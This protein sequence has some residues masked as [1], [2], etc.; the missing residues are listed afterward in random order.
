[1]KRPG[2]AR[3]CRGRSDGSRPARCVASRSTRGDSSPRSCTRNAAA[4]AERTRLGSDSP[5]RRMKW[6]SWANRSATSCMASI[7][8]RV[9]PTP[10]GPVKVTSRASSSSR[11]EVTDTQLGFP[12]QE[13]ASRKWQRNGH[14][15]FRIMGSQ[16]ARLAALGRD[17]VL[18]RSA[19]S[20]DA[21]IDAVSRRGCSMMPRSRSL[22]D[23]ALTP[24]RSASSCCVSPASTRSWRSR[25][26][27]PFRS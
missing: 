6:T 26:A 16:P 12:A 1:M 27:N 18:R 5:S 21:S 9:F 19:L 20:P 22:T 23:R 11:A 7:A 4:S 15:S 2:D 17:L 25:A 10:P 3:G 8:S 14:W 24:E 13:L